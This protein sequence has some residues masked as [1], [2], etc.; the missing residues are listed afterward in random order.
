VKE[1]NITR[2]SKLFAL[3]INVFNPKENFEIQ[4]KYF[5]TETLS[6]LLNRAQQTECDILALRFNIENTENIIEATELLNTILPHIYKPLMI[7]GTGRTDIDIQLLPKLVK[8]LDRQSII[9]FA[10]ETSY[11]TIVPEVLKGNHYL[12]LKTPID[13]N[14]AKEL[15]ILSADLGLPRD[16]IIMNTDIGGLGYGYEYGYSI[17]EKII[18][19]GEKGDEYLNLPLLSEAPLES[20]KTKEARLDTFPKSYGK[21]DSRANMIEISSAAGILSAGANIIVMANPD[22]IVIM[23]GLI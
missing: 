18:I 2:K 11:K 20:L 8:N 6:D 14:L 13:I 4:K 12:V 7:C 23:K 15:N 9:S 1:F 19:E 3:L 22:N 17:M 16:R 21:L 10:D 5:K